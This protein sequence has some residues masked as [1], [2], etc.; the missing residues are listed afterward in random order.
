MSSRRLL[1]DQVQV[2]FVTRRR[3][4][5]HAKT[6]RTIRS[7]VVGQLIARRLH[8]KCL[9]MSHCQIATVHVTY[10]IVYQLYIYKCLRTWRDDTRP[11]IHMYILIKLRACG[12]CARHAHATQVV[13]FILS[14]ISSSDVLLCERCTRKMHLAAGRIKRFMCAPFG[15]CKYWYWY[16]HIG[17]F[18]L[19]KS[20]RAHN[21]RLAHI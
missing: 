16:E 8:L 20:L 2:E 7:L 1:R 15:C 13:T 19:S 14:C 21:F 17:I 10:C 5:A 4:D 9:K 11:N 6:I 18:P 3:C 12:A